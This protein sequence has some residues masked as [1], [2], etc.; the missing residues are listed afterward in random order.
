[1]QE[2]GKVITLASGEYR[3]LTPQEVTELRINTECR[4]V[5]LNLLERKAQEETLALL[6]NDTLALAGSL[7][8]L[9]VVLIWGQ[10]MTYWMLILVIPLLLISLRLLWGPAWNTFESIGC[11]PTLFL[12]FPMA[13]TSYWLF[14]P[15]WYV[16]WVSL[17]L[18]IITLTIF[19]YIRR[20]KKTETKR[21]KNS[22]PQEALEAF[23]TLIQKS[24]L[25]I[26]ADGYYE[27]LADSSAYLTQ[28]RMG[29][30]VDKDR[31]D[32]RDVLKDFGGLSKVK[33]EIKD[34]VFLCPVQYH[35]SKDHITVFCS[36]DL[37]FRRENWRETEIFEGETYD[38]KKEEK[39]R[40]D[41]RFFT[42]LDD[43]WYLDNGEYHPPSAEDTDRLRKAGFL[44]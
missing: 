22:H 41:R 14:F 36:I 12:L 28:V 3:V 8:A 34:C 5:P 13:S 6:L 4:E 10:I 16:R 1:M 40:Y 38:V 25:S 21:L 33:F 27:Y 24:I 18:C 32:I 35:P 31:S 2:A 23:Y 11:L 7:L 26:G 15:S 19:L 43:G 9:V 30:K 39:R 20:V 44:L 37:R 42:R 29:E 17:A